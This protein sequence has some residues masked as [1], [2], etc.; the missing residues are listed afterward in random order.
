MTQPNWAEFRFPLYNKRI[1]TL[2][3][4]GDITA[5]DVEFLQEF[6]KIMHKAVGTRIEAEDT[7]PTPNPAREE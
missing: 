1:A 5:E 7:P 3:V 2:Y 4:P 6:L